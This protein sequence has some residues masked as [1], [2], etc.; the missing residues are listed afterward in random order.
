MLRSVLRGRRRRIM[1]GALLMVGHQTGK[2]TLPVVVGATIDA[3]IVTGDGDALVLWLD[4]LAATFALL[5]DLR[6][7]RAARGATGGRRSAPGARRPRRLAGRSVA[8]P[9]RAPRAHPS[10]L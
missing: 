10:R 9:G 7:G 5:V 4:V 6:A 3:A 1:L 8:L 2:A